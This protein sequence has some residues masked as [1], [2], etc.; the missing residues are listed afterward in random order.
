MR[1]LVKSIFLIFVLSS[2]SQI[3][4]A[5]HDHVTFSQRLM[6]TD[7]KI[8]LNYSKS[9]D[10]EAAV[11]EAYLEGNRLNLIFSDYI[12]NS[13]LSKFSRSSNS[14]S[15]EKIKLS[16]EL[17]EVLKYC[18]KLY[19]LS[20]GSFDPTLGPLTRL[21][22]ISRH[23][24]LFPEKSKLANALAR[25]GAKNLKL[26]ETQQSGQLLAP[27]MV[28]DLGGVAKGYIADRMLEILQVYGFYRSL[29]D[30]GGDL[31]IGDA[32]LGSDGWKID[33]RGRKYEKLT[34]LKL[35]NCAVATSGD[36]EQFLK[37]NDTQYSHIIDPKTGIGLANQAQ[38][39]V[40]APT[41][42]EAD[43]LASTFLVTGFEKA[44]ALI[45]KT[46]ARH[47]Y[48]LQKRGDQTILNEVH[49]D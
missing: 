27:N 24:R 45:K 2:H 32:P 8:V 25:S 33:I 36:T 35:A 41:G 48:F 15:G 38:A 26:D 40:I 44:S 34:M 6:G 16:I 42:M 37:I 30:A 12:A 43:S 28:L 7:V 13:E 20:D 5:D 14:A 29:V 17:F 23:Q 3:L 46:N 4:S 18:L 11:K 22:R 9:S 10:L 49:R 31:R 19:A 47:L 1:I 39:T 21:W